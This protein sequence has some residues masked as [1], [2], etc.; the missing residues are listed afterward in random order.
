MTDMTELFGNVISA[1]TR[2]QAIEDGVLKDLFH[3][4]SEDPAVRSVLEQHHSALSHPQGLCIT[5]SLWALIEEAVSRKRD[6]ND[7]AGV[8][9]DIFWMGR[10]AVSDGIHAAHDDG[11]LSPRAFEVYIGSGRPRDL[12]RVY[13]Q[14]GV[15]DD[16]SRPCLTFM[17]SEDL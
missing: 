13:V 5:A 16:G 17:L 6:Y 9:H 15:V 1:Y 7:R 10:K 14:W 12:Q 11:D 2:G 8:L 4:R 3:P